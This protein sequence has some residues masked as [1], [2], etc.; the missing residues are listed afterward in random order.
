MWIFT[1][2]VTAAFDSVI[3]PLLG[4]IF[5]PLTTFAYVIFWDPVEGLTGLAWLAVIVALI[6]DLAIN[7]GTIW[8]N[9]SRI[10]NR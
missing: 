6:I 4:L 5:L 9:R 2:R 8:G 1:D 7:G 10:M 3:V